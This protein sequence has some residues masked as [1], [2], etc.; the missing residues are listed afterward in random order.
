MKHRFASRSTTLIGVLAG[1]MT[2][3]PSTAQAQ[4]DPLLS[5]KRLPP[6]VIIVVD[7]SFRMLDDGDGNYYDPRTY[8]RADD[9]SVATALG[10][11]AASY[12][13][14]YTNLL[15]DTQQ[16]TNHKYTATSIVATPSTAPTYSTFWAPTRLEIAKSAIAQ[17][18]GENASMVRFG[19]MRL[20]QRTPAWSTA[21]SACEYPVVVSNGALQVTHD[22]NPCPIG[23]GSGLDGRYGLYPPTVS[24]ANY[25][26]TAA[27][28]TPV[29]VATGSTN[30]TTNILAITTKAVQDTT[31]TSLIP[32]GRDTSAYVDRPI[33]LALTDARAEAQAVMAAE[34]AATRACR[35]TIVVLIT[36]GKDSGDASYTNT[37]NPVAT[38]GTFASV[39]AGSGSGAVT[40][41]VPIVVVGV[42]PAAADEAQLTSIASASG[43]TYIRA[44][45][46]V[47]VARAINHA[48][49]LGFQNAVDVDAMRSSEYQLVS[50]IVGTVNLTNATSAT[51]ATLPNTS[52]S[53][54]SGATSGQAIPQRANFMITAG[55]GLPGFDGRLRAFRTFAP[56][57]DATKPTGW[58]FVKDGT[59]LWP[60]LDDRPWLTG[61][62]RVPLSEPTRNIYTYIP[63]GSGGGQMVAFTT[64]NAA[65]L[66]PHLGGA[67]PM[68]LIPFVR[69]QPL[70]AIIGSTPAIMDP[71]SLDPPPDIAYGFSDT[72][73][74]YAAVHKDRRS[75]IFFGA[76]DGM[77]HA[78][79]ARTGYEV[80][81]FIPYNLLP[82]LRTLVD[83]QPV[84]QF[85]YFVDSSPKIA[86]VKLGGVWRTMLVIGQSNGGT[87]YQAFDVTE[88]GMG[89]PPDA[90]GLSAVGSMLTQFD[91]PDESIVFKWA[92]PNY[93]SFDPNINFVQ[94]L[95]DGFPGN[96][97]RL[98]GD[99]KAG[100]TLVEKTVGFT[101]SDP[102][103]GP[104]TLDRSVTA[105]ITGSGYFPDIEQ[106]G[107]LNRGGSS[108]P[109]RAGRSLYVLDANTGLPIGNT[110]GTS[111]AGI[112][113][114]DL[115]EVSNSRKNTLQA[116]IT[117]AGDT[118]SPVVNRAYAGEGDG[119]YWHFDLTSTGQITA[120]QL[121]ATGQPIYSSSALL[122]VG[123]VDRYLFFSTGSDNLSSF[124][125][126]GAGQF[127]LFGVKDGTTSAVLTQTLTSVSSTA[128]NS[129]T[130][131]ERPSTAPTVAGDI[132]FF[133]TTTDST[134]AAC[135]SP[136]T[137]KLY[138][139]TYLGS[140][141]YDSNGNGKLDK[142][143][144]PVVSTS[145]GRATAPFIVDQHLFM[146]TTGP[147]GPGV[148]IF[149]DAQDFNNG[150]GSV[151]LRILSWR[152]IR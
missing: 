146:G 7:T 62:A 80:W 48:V 138:A 111:C 105:V 94:A 140:A 83:G 139:F 82:K 95:T 72:P 107:S 135:T 50:P 81:A 96:K 47:D 75:I 113:C 30:A 39:T 147:N 46:P 4:L 90:D 116:D 63:N 42:K 132:V 118:G 125:P 32:A 71:P 25:L 33:D 35:N 103:V 58:K 87:F 15:I 44:V 102:A 114:L 9:T 97:I 137:A 54:T 20:R 148:T 28:G 151:G 3:L 122:F 120:T 38:A 133:T 84:E 12:R 6:N 49:Q 127:K 16:D 36:G 34:A 56:V 130:N 78:V 66:A 5:I 1:L 60:D 123:T 13:R 59:R 152:E 99:L 93:S 136:P 74:S 10:V 142:T 19:L 119:R 141:A 129:P 43:G 79:D 131:G 17:V 24:V 115:G 45:S 2:G 109:I 29:V 61:L 88:A 55:F 112:G 31:G 98:Y 121:L 92:F 18:V 21:N 149:G 76:N 27:L 124:T 64:A 110:G 40:R 91:A 51:G 89:V 104:L 143:E 53:S 117:A 77:V 65:L 8:L 52:I 37:H 26:T 23:N 126:G 11:T 108:S 41:R 128:G 67:D 150:V 101:W 70:G 73:N 22:T 86:D 145:I 68:T 57:A 134:N 14:K 85:D 144:S 69:L 106:S 100:A